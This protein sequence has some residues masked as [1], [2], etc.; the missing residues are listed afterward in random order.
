MLSSPQAAALRDVLTA[1]RR[2]A[3][4]LSIVVYPA[5]VQGTGAAA[6]IAAAIVRASMRAADRNEC[7]V[8]LLVRGGG[9]IEDLWAF[10]SEAVARAVL[11][12]PIPVVSGVGHETDFTIAD[13]VADL[14][15]ATPTAA[16]ELASPNVAELRRELAIAA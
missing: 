15:A 8:L 16:A 5:P 9:S 6:Q 2:R 4:H 13:F 12:C 7:D 10:N 14:R 11:A 1:L 3:P